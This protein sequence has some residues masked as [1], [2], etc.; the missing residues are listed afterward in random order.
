MRKR[1][2]LLSAYDA[3][4]HAYWRHQLRNQLTEFEWTEL[5]LS[6][7]YFNWRIRGNAMQ[8]GRRQKATG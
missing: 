1:L 3:P 8:C 6:P 4:S 5:R 7:R 2:L